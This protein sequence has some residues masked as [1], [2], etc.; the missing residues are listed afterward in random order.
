MKLTRKLIPAVILAA[1]GA[2]AH[3]QS[4]NILNV[5]A[6]N[7]TFSGS[8]TLTFSQ[9][10]LDALNTASISAVNFAPATSNIVGTPGAYTTISASAPMS[11]MLLNTD[12]LAVTGVSTKGG[13]SLTAPGTVKSISTGGS[14]TV[15]D[16][17]VD[18]TSKVVY[19]TIIGGNGVGTL[20]NFALWNYANLTGPTTYAGPGNYT[21]DITGLSL[22]ST[23]F[24]VFSQALGLGSLGKA[25][26]QGISDYGSIHSVLNTKLVLDTTPSIPEPSTYALMGLGVAGIALARRRKA[27]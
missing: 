19:A 21:D 27:A 5:V 15:T 23:G 22:T 20:N 17:S 18:L 13:M 2:T 14:L 10:L 6:G 12:T 26:M 8:G 25:A 16:I 7:V 9:D 3:A 11:S 1:M 24:T 4:S